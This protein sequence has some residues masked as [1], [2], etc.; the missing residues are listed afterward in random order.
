MEEILEG[1][2]VVIV[3]AA[4]DDEQFCNGTIGILDGLENE[5][6]WAV[7]RDSEGYRIATKTYKRATEL[8]KALL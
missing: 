4:W 8:Q 2:I 5:Q 1:E 7:V 3:Q 6:E